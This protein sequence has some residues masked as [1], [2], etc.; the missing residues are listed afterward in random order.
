MMRAVVVVVMLVATA[1]RA[2]ARP[3]IP[4]ALAGVPVGED[5]AELLEVKYDGAFTLGGQKVLAFRQQLARELQ[6][7]HGDWTGERR[8]EVALADAATKQIVYRRDVASR[9]YTV[10]SGE[11]TRTEHFAY[12]ARWHDENG[13][14]E[15]ELILTKT[16]GEGPQV[17]VFQ[18]R[19]GDL[20]EISSDMVR[21]PR[22][23]EDTF[24]LGTPGARAVAP[25]L[26]ARF[27]A[28][29]DDGDPVDQVLCSYADAVAASQLD[30][31]MPAAG[32]TITVAPIATGCP[33][34]AW[35][36]RQGRTLSP[37]RLMVFVATTGQ[38]AR[39][40][41]R[42]DVL[43]ATEIDLTEK[44]DGLGNIGWIERWVIDD[45]LWVFAEV[46]GDV[47]RFAVVYDPYRDE[48]HTWRIDE[49]A[50]A[51]LTHSTGTT[52]HFELVLTGPEGQRS[53]WR[54]EAT[55]WH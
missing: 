33:G 14:G 42:N 6:M 16:A 23:P 36:L 18:L 40:Q 46:S 39:V 22:A 28:R 49:H 13:D 30:G 31:P 52:G 38:L 32:E 12:S 20:L 24:S 41:V 2:E 45:R 35:A 50:T 7:G 11:E 21:C 43:S 19:F 37:S 9:S 34:L 29:V 17:R 8:T 48:L 1:S 54:R 47:E 53:V 55:S 27:V 26:V 4:K 10:V 51:T 5:D 15:P 44:V 25:T 3:K